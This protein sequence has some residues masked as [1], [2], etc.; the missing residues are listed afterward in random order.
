MTQLTL[1]MRNELAK[2]PA[3]TALVGGGA[4]FPDWIFADKS[5]G[6]VENSQTSMIVISQ[7]G[8]WA[9]PNQHNTMRFPRIF[10][11]V[12]SDPTRNDDNSVRVDDADDKIEKL[13]TLISKHFHTVNMNNDGQIIQ[14]G[15]QQ[16]FLTGRGVYIAGSARQQETSYSDIQ[17]GNGGRMGTAVYGVN[18]L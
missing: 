11:D 9:P 6:K 13:H 17:N 7:D 18:L 12:W 10:V 8:Q 5:Y 14:W 1:A 4:T 3:I 15:S 2:D 16:D